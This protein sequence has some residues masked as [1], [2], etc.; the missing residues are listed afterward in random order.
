MSSESTGFTSFDEIAHEGSECILNSPD[1]RFKGNV[2]I[3]RPIDCRLSYNND[4]AEE[5]RFDRAKIHISSKNVKISGLRI[6]GSIDVGNDCADV[7]LKECHIRGC[8][9]IGSSCVR[10]RLE[11][12]EIE[13]SASFGLLVS[14]DSSV[15]LINTSFRNNLVGLSLSNEVAMGVSITSDPG[16]P[17]C[18][19]E[20]CAFESNST[21]IVIQ[22]RIVSGPEGAHTAVINPGRILGYSHAE[23]ESMKELKWD[24]SI[25]GRL[26]SP[27][28]FKQWPI[29]T[30]RLHK[31]SVKR[32]GFRSNKRMCRFQ[33]DGDQ[34]LLIE[35][36]PQ[37]FDGRKRIR[38]DTPPVEYSKAQ[39]NLYKVLEISPGSDKAA[40][41]S[42]FR[43]LALLHHPDKGGG[44]SHAFVLI[45]RARDELIMLL[46]SNS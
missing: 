21:D 12:C 40:I 5:E 6:S 11:S 19:L 46:D 18:Q 27:L 2:D 17:L 44:E 39:L 42:A 43:R 30:E 15:S 8:I 32:R 31:V 26:E 4:L 10:V 22:I 45:K 28:S 35:D 25:S 41:T 20:G 29:A 16:P 24:V 23:E 3:V 14:S 34:I 9:R 36:P 7:T 13:G 37:S 1:T 38:K 33:I